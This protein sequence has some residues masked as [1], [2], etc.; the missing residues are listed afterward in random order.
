MAKD[1]LSLYDQ[2]FDHVYR[3]TYFKTGNKWDT[4]D[5]VSDTFRKAFEKYATLQAHPKAWLMAIA[6]NTVIDFYRKKKEVVTDREEL[7][8]QVYDYSLEEVL[9]RHDE[10]RCLK[11]ALQ[12][13]PKEELEIINLKYFSE[14]THQEMGRILGKT[15]DAVKR[16]SLRIV[17]KLAESVHRCLEG[18]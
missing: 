8:K 18:K 15:V 9:G 16:K 6:R 13:L 11:K 5:L 1:F 4:D 17:R 7:E 12:S 3:Y 2:Y 14:L 10:L